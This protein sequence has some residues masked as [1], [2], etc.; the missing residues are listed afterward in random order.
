LKHI[1]VYLFF[2]YVL[3]YLFLILANPEP[4]SSEIVILDKLKSKFK[5]LTPI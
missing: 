5:D 2:Q 3:Y 1:T 4:V